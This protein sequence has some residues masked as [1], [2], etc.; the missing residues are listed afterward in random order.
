MRSSVLKAEEVR[1]SVEPCTH[2]EPFLCF[3]ANLREVNT[4]DVTN[5]HNC[6]REDQRDRL[7]CGGLLQIILYREESHPYA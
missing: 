7:I 6:I 1:E 5:I 4:Q 2:A 3:R